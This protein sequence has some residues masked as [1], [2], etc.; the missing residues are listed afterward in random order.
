MDILEAIQKAIHAKLNK[1]LMRHQI[2]VFIDP[3]G[4]RQLSEM[5]PMINWKTIYNVKLV[6]VDETLHNHFSVI[7]IRSKFDV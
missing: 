2:T 5:N 4:H 7:D 3:E 6:F 1:G